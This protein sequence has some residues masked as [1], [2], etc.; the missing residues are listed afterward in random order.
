M[1]TTAATA[2]AIAANHRELRGGSPQNVQAVISP[3]EDLPPHLLR[4]SC[5]GLAFPDKQRILADKRSKIAGARGTTNATH[6]E[7]LDLRNQSANEGRIDIWRRAKRVK[8][9]I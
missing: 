5:L 3:L 1:V 2:S 9:Y 4:V 8:K 6:Y 7:N